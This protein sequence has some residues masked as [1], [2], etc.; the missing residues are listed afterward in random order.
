[1]LH[2][3]WLSLVFQRVAK[4]EFTSVKQFVAELDW[5]YHNAVVYYSG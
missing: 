4:K 1:M 5:I 3:K 2:I